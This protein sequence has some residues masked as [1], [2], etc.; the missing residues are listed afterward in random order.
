VAIVGVHDGSFP[1]FF[2][3][4][5][6]VF[7]LAGMGN[8]STYRMIP[9]IFTALGGPEVKRRAAAAIGIAGAVGAFG[10]FL[11]QVVL[12]QASLSK[13]P[14][15]SIPALWTFLGAYVVLGAMTWFF[16]VRRSAGVRRVASLAHVSV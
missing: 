2:G 8:G 6:A 15:W 12:R 4:Y 10:G 1:V 7:L 11:I 14:D 9:S 16:Y 13:T 5:M 3:A